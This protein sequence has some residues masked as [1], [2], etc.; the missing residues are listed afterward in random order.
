MLVINSE[1]IS[2]LLTP[3]GLLLL[4]FDLKHLM[5]GFDFAEF[6]KVV[7][8]YLTQVELNKSTFNNSFAIIFK[9][10]AIHDL[11]MLISLLIQKFTVVCSTVIVQVVRLEL[12]FC[13]FL[14]CPLFL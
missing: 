7:I 13:V 14:F 6:F 11:L 12:K 3:R 5:E 10:Q 9:P 8:K 2:K 1:N 4:W